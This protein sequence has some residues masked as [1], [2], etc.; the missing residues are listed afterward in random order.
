MERFYE[1]R[2][3]RQANIAVGAKAPSEAWKI[4]KKMVDDDN[5]ERV[6]SQSVRDVSVDNVECMKEYIAKAKSL[7][8]NVKYHGMEVTQQEIGRRVLDGLSPAYEP[9][10]LA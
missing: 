8:L 6:H 7:A 1:S 2:R 10:P 4:L 3:K 5:S 9:R